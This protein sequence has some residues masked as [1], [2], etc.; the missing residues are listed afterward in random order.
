MQALGVEDY[1]DDQGRAQ[2]FSYFRRD[3]TTLEARH[4]QGETAAVVNWLPILAQDW[5][6]LED[7]ISR[8][9]LVT[10]RNARLH[11]EL[12]RLLG[13]YL[14]LGGYCPSDQVDAPDRRIE[15]ALVYSPL[16]RL[17]PLDQIARLGFY[18]E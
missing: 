7:A 1:V 13:D 8:A 3:A 14:A 18:T 15:V 11:D 16:G 5:F 12:V 4:I 17:L 6:I 10:R 2:K 9:T